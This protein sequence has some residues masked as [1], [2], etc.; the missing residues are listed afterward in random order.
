M[1][2]LLS[3][4]FVVAFQLRAARRVTVRQLV[5][6][7]V[8]V[9]ALGVVLDLLNLSTR[10]GPGPTPAGSGLLS[11]A[12]GFLLCLPAVFVVEEVVFRGVLDSY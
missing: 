7:V 10:G 2:L 5:I 3:I 8:V 11:G 9:C 12:Y 1:Y 6:C 4:P